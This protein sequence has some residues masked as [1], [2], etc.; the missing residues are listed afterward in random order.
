MREMLIM[1][2]SGWIISGGICILTLITYW[3]GVYSTGWR[4]ELTLLLVIDL[5]VLGFLII[6]TLIITFLS[7]YKIV[8]KN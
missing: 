8:R 6:L 3:F 5:G 1:V 2:V 4:F 7:R